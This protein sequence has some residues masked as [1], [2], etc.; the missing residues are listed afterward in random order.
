MIGFETKRATSVVI[1]P[2]AIPL[3]A[4]D[5]RPISVIQTAKGLD[6]M[7]PILLA[8]L[9][10]TAACTHTGFYALSDST[11]SDRAMTFNGTVLSVEADGDFLLET[12]G[13]LLL[14]DVGDT[15]VKVELGDRVTVTGR[16]DNDNDEAD[17]PELD[18]ESVTDW[19]PPAAPTK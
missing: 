16:T 4:P 11:P 15:D 18:A 6:Y 17:A 1:C 12:S 8:P 2:V 9:L 10:V 13:R 3:V 14:V 7:K 5:R 19:L